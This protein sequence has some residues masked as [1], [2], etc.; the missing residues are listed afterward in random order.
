MVFA[1]PRSE[2]QTVA[3]DEQVALRGSDIESPPFK[4]IAGHLITIGSFV[5]VGMTVNDF[6][7]VTCPG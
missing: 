5:V 7:G 6:Q 4:P 1:R 2:L 3:V